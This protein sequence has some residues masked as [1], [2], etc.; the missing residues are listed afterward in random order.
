[1]KL[2]KIILLIFIT[3]NFSYA[4]KLIMGYRE[5]ERKPLI[6]GVKNNTGLYLE[7]YSLAAKRI[8]YELEVIRKPKK[9]ILLEMKQGKIDFYPGFTFTTPR[10]KF[11]YFMENGLPGGDVGISL[12]EFPDIKSF[13]DLLGQRV[14]VAAGGP[15]EA[16]L[17]ELDHIKLHRVPRLSIE[18]A[19]NLIKLKRDDF[20]VYNKSS[21][22]YY[23]KMNNID[24]L[25]V[26]KDCCGGYK[27]MYLGF[28]LNS[29][30]FSYFK[31]PNFDK[32]KKVSIENLPIV[33]DKA[34]VAY[35]FQK[36]LENMQKE[37]ITQKLY[38]KYYN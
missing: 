7:L 21:I 29:D 33:I 9:R 20:Y 23:I 35:K 31:N 1:M 19:F 14:L 27:P 3:L 18:K 28:S 10:T 6:G 36:A 2:Q 15:T 34:S 32:S 38:E 17:S 11:S 13:N 24:Y 26:H 16:R 37:G 25:K 5:D 12:K 4:N 22:D 30:K 8:G